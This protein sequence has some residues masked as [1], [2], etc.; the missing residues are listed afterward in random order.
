MIV[1]ARAPLRVDLAG[2]WTDVAPYA[3]R[4]GGAVLNVAVTL[5]AHATVE[6]GGEGVRLHARDLGGHVTARRAAD[7]RPEGEL[8][9]L[10]A[11]ARK[12]APTDAFALSTWCDAPPGS[13]LGGSAALGVALVAALSA[14]RGEDRLPAELAADAFELERVDAGVVGGKQ[15]QYAAALGGVQFLS[16]EDPALTATRLRLPAAAYYELEQSLV[17]CYSGVS[18]FSDATHRTVWRRYEAG[19]RDVAAALDGIKGCAL[20][21][22]RALENGDLPETARLMDE[23]WRHQRALAEGM[24]TESMATLERAARAAGAEGVKACGAGAG[25]CLA[26][27]AKP[28]CEVDVA[29]ALRDA[30]GTVLPARFDTRGV[31][32]WS[33]LPR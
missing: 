28:G 1:R 25:G 9:L 16:F 13:G 6:T 30:G 21:M 31:V 20:Q 27:L 18:R 10:Q 19:D 12:Y 15:D 3:A 14:A 26:V 5:Y 32:S 22:R 29:H 4:S 33:P 24:Q 2:G 11:A 7:L 17:L 8:A 23:N